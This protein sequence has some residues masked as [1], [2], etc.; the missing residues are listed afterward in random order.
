MDPQNLHNP[1]IR[2]VLI[3]IGWLA[4]VLGVIGIFLPLIP[5]TPFLLLAASCFA[6][7]STRF[8]DWLL[9]QPH[10]GPY[11]QM[12]LN[13]KGIPTRAKISILV[14]MW[15]SMTVSALLFGKYL[16]VRIIMF[17]I[18]CG[19][20]IYIVRLPTLTLVEKTD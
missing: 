7:S 18:A 11:I 2:Y 20:T 3:A 19:V 14:V 10:L 12:Y 5:T 16:A 1:V 9:N 17:I 15:L 13:G 6:K 8:H 4:V